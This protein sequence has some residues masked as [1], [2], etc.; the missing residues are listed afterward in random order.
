MVHRKGLTRMTDT[1][2]DKA[3]SQVDLPYV[4]AELGYPTKED[5][6]LEGHK[7]HVRRIHDARPIAGELSLDR[8]GFTLMKHKSALAGK[9][10]YGLLLRESAAYADELT[11]AIK[12]FM[13]ASWVVAR[14]GGVVV[15]SATK[16]NPANPRGYARNKGGIEVPYPNVH[17]DYTADSAKHLAR[18]ENYQQGIPERPFS[19]LVI[20]QAWRAFSLPPQDRPLAT[21]DASTL[22]ES[23]TFVAGNP[24]DPNDLSG[25]VF[26]ARMVLF[27][28]EQRWY[29]FS[30]MQ[31]DEVLLFKGYDSDPARNAAPPHS[32]FTNTALGTRA[33]PRESVEGRFFVYY[34]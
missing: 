12:E 3:P 22:G 10:D 25:D 13:G 4:E 5:P 8:E 18:A 6:T 27:N 33:V 34:D 20:I 1:K 21:M 31:R 24:P 26:Q 32:S 17:M 30:Q 28:P 23:D 11:P 15:R 19:R 16:I 2:A 9:G 7:I 29:Y 14:R